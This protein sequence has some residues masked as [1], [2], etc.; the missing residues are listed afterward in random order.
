MSLDPEQGNAGEFGTFCEGCKHPQLLF[1][2]WTA[3][4]GIRSDEL[5]TLRF[6]LGLDLGLEGGFPLQKVLTQR[7]QLLRR[8]VPSSPE[9]ALFEMT[10]NTLSFFAWLVTARS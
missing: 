1:R 3:E 4:H 8:A 10:I 2:D 5:F 9:I 6:L 7:L